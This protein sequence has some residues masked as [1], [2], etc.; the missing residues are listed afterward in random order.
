MALLPRNGRVAPLMNST[1][2]VV[3]LILVLHGGLT[4]CAGFNYEIHEKCMQAMTTVICCSR[5]L[6]CLSLSSCLHSAGAPKPLNPSLGLLVPC[7]E[8]QSGV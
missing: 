3:P 1:L 7:S 5:E 2:I 4:E 8:H 6:A